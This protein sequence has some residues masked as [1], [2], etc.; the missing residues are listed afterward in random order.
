M[1]E[2]AMEDFPAAQLEQ[3][4]APPVEYLPAAQ[5]AQVLPPM[6]ESEYLPLW[7][8]TQLPIPGWSAYEPA[9][10]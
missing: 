8:G 1:Y 2:A 7:H 5:S 9:A 10:H 3:A 4:I 6:D